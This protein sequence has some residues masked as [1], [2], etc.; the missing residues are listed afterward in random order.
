MST[1]RRRESTATL[2][3]LLALVL[4]VA[5]VWWYFE[6]HPL[7]EQEAAQPPSPRPADAQ[8]VTVRFLQDGD[9]LGVTAQ[10]PGKW[11]PTVDEVQV[12]LLG[13]DAPEMH[14]A[15]GLPQCWATQAKAELLRLAPFGGKLWLVGD[16]QL[17]DKFGRYLVY[18]WTPDGK[19]V[20]EQLAVAGAVRELSIPPN[21]AYEQQLH[22]K[23]ATARAAKT[24]LWG[25][26]LS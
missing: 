21:Y 11:L 14:G 9:S 24:G 5:G 25:K 23:I 18:A 22:N 1:A 16:A 7:T 4:V 3:W 26:C 8:E 15:D 19:F 17:Q 2:F 10:A 20:N 6:T 12:R 13:I